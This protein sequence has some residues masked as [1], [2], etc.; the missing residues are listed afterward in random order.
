[1]S[2]V[3]H[4][5][6]GIPPVARV[7]TQGRFQGSK[8]CLCLVSPIYQVNMGTSFRYGQKLLLST[9]KC[10]KIWPLFQIYT[11]SQELPSSII[12]K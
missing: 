8:S 5:Y 2:K 12:V 10:W 11:S 6:D 1:M 3:C 9:G 7:L 4:L